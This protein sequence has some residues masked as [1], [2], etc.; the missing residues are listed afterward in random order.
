M[1]ER[2]KWYADLWGLRLGV[3]LIADLMQSCKLDIDNF[4]FWQPILN[5]KLFVKQLMRLKRVS[6]FMKPDA[7]PESSDLK[8]KQHVEISGYEINYNL[9]SSIENASISSWMPEL[10]KEQKIIW[11]EISH[12][13]RQELFPA[14]AR[15]V[16]RW[17]ADR[18]YVETEILVGKPFWE[19][20]EIEINKELI[21]ASLLS[22]QRLQGSYDR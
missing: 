13:E 12:T 7:L 10:R 19:T 9:I 1:V 15:L 22:F 18:V 5:G 21:S 6:A 20:V 14:S 17:R 11:K 16:D 8:E 2:E 4:I 3:L